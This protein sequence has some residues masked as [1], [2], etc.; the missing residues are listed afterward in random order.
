MTY[1]EVLLLYLE[2]LDVSQNE[3]ARR[4]KTNP[5]TINAL[6]KGRAKNPTL[7]MARDI[8]TALGVPLQEMADRMDEPEKDTHSQESD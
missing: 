8:A 2:E 7:Q 1:G 5:S 6:V 4:L 3:L